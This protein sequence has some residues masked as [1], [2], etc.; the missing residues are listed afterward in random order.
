MRNWQIVSILTITVVLTV[1]VTA[2]ALAAFNAPKNGTIPTYSYYPNVGSQ[3]G[4]T[5]LTPFQPITPTAPKTTQISITEAQT[6]AQNYLLQLGNP[7]LAVRGVDEYAQNFYVTIYE[8]STN[9]GAFNLIIDKSTGILSPETGPNISWNTKYSSNGYVNA[10]SQNGYGYG[11]GPGGEGEMG[12][13]SYG[14]TASV[15][16]TLMPIILSQATATAQQY[17]NAYY[18]GTIT[19]NVKTF[20]GYYTVEV[21]NNGDTYGILSVNGYSGQVW[22]HNWHGNFIQ[23]TNFP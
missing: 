20:Y 2:V 4:T 6:L 19:G 7:D 18:R 23:E 9:A 8:R 3:Q 12:G 21:L 14:G 17:L 13:G 16:T 1:L 11:F 15:P 22:Y 5:P 10:P